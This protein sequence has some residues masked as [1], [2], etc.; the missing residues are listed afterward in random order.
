MELS[1]S[2]KSKAAGQGVL[3]AFLTATTLFPL[4]ALVHKGG[5]LAKDMLN[6][7]KAYD[8]HKNPK[9]EPSSTNHSSNAEYSGVTIDHGTLEVL[10]ENG[11]KTTEET[12]HAF[13]S[14]KE[15]TKVSYAELENLFTK[16]GMAK[17]ATEN[18]IITAVVAGIAIGGAA[19]TTVG[20]LKKY[21]ETNDQDIG[22][23][24][25]E[26]TQSSDHAVAENIK[27]S[28][29]E[30]WADKMDDAKSKLR[31]EEQAAQDTQA[32]WEDKAKAQSEELAQASR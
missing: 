20:A 16:E 26:Y 28:P 4:A 14:A 12:A 18:K 22:K 5:S 6:T 9:A 3:S 7:V 29:H 32:N 21:R 17:Y 2:Q 30:N 10:S 19:M 1:A 13:E 8:E 23:S 24:F 25:R 11:H 15:K 31:P 27:A